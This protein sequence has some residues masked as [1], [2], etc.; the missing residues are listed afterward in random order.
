MKIFV[1]GTLKV[2][3]RLSQPFNEVRRSVVPATVK[4]TM[5]SVHGSYP[6]VVLS[7][8]T[9]IK[10]ELHQYDV[11]TGSVLK[12][13]DAIEGYRPDDKLN[14]YNR[15]EVEVTTAG[16]KSV[17]AMM[18]VFNRSTSGLERLAGGYWPV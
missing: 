14:L 6:A 1:Y 4:G 13:L 8:D 10:G 12:H 7:G 9:E 16:G 5:Y 3:G 17:K 15:V 18:Y 11:E 2:G